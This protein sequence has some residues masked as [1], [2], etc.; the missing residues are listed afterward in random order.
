MTDLLRRTLGATITLETSLAPGLPLTMTDPGQVENVLL[1]LAINARDAMPNGGRLIVETQRSSLD[2][3]Y[4]DDH[5]E[6]VPGDYVSLS[7]T[8]TGSG[9]TEEVKRRA[10]EPFYTTK[11]PGAGSGLGLSMVHG[12]VKQSGGHVQIYSELGRGTTIRI[13]LP[14]DG[15]SEE[16]KVQQDDVGAGATP[17]PARE[18]ILTVEDDPRVRRIS[19][20][21][22]KLLGYQVLEAE[23]GAAAFAI[24]Q[25]GAAF[26]LLFTDVIMAGGMSGIEL[27]QKAREKRPDLKV[28]FTSGFAEPAV[29]TQALLSENAGW[30]GKPYSTEQLEEKLRALLDS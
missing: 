8:D 16:K 23:S 5:L 10:F 6:V 22:L 21:R 1:N 25:Q 17:G 4:A 15:G 7:V 18:T 13:Y 24:I 9:M 3:I 30:L 19:L 12:F 20:R 29:L 14:A 26:D 2:E 11:G 28:L 27:A